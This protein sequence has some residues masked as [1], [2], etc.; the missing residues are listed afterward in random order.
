VEEK[1]GDLIKDEKKKKYQIENENEN[2]EKA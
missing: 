2:E 1:E